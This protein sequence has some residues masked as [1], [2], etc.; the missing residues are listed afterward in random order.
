M[1]LASATIGRAQSEISSRA[2]LTLALPPLCR[3]RRC[4]SSSRWTA[5]ASPLSPM[6]SRRGGQTSYMEQ[7]LAPAVVGLH[8]Y[9]DAMH[10]Y[11]C[12]TQ[13]SRASVCVLSM[14]IHLTNT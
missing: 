5:A 9:A 6:W 7:A 4:S 1:K 11:V 3:A 8:L 12:Q 2:E 10:H 14:S 13:Y